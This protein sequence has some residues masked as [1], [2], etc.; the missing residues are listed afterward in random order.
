[1]TS[2]FEEIIEDDLVY[3]DALL[4]KECEDWFINKD[5]KYSIE[6]TGKCVFCLERD[7]EYI[8]DLISLLGN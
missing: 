8:R 6:S 7:P 2:P 3:K 5:D 1:M 4:C